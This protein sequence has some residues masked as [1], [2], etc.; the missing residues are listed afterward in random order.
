MK[1]K[2]INE[3]DILINNQGVSLKVLKLYRKGN[4]LKADVQ[5]TKTKYTKTVQFHHL[6]DGKA[7]DPY[8]PSKFGKAYLGVPGK[9]DLEDYKRW[10]NLLQRVYDPINYPTYTDVTVCERWH[11]FEFFLTDLRQMDN[12][13]KPNMHLDKDLLH[14]EC[15]LYSPENCQLIHINEN[16]SHG[17]FTG[18]WVAERNGSIIKTKFSSEM[19]QLIGITAAGV[20]QAESRKRVTI[21]GWKVSKEK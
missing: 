7:R 18:L 10:E 13:G 20:R 17:A 21:N 2:E 5:F 15:R 14:K 12:Y 9:Y 11:C 4:S 8:A 16:S 19:G 3:N 1:Y 6:K